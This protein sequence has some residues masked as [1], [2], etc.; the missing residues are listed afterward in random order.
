[1]YISKAR[2]GEILLKV[3]GKDE[4]DRGMDH[5]GEYHSFCYVFLCLFDNIDNKKKADRHYTNVY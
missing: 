4:M 1:M 2:W 3:L 5:K